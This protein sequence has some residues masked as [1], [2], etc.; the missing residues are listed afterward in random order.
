MA[1]VKNKTTERGQEFWS[2][3][4]TI[5]SQVRSTQGANMRSHSTEGSSRASVPEEPEN[6][7]DV[8]NV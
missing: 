2:H 4:E 6:T 8:H 5:A 7:S 3:V 1:V